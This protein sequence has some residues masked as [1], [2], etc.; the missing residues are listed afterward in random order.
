MCKI[1]KKKKCKNVKK[2]LQFFKNYNRNTNKLK[3]NRNKKNK[4]KI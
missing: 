4:T 1:T 3:Q 2:V